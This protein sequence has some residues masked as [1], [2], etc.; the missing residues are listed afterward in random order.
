MEEFQQ[1]DDESDGI[2]F[3]KHP[4]KKYM[5][6]GLLLLVFVLSVVSF[7]GFR[8]KSVNPP[9]KPNIEINYSIYSQRYLSLMQ[10][11]ENENAIAAQ[12]DFLKKDG[13]VF[14][15]NIR[16]N[17]SL[18]PGNASIIDSLISSGDYSTIHTDLSNF[19]SDMKMTHIPKA[20]YGPT[21]YGDTYNNQQV[22]KSDLKY[23]LS[24]SK[25]GSI[26]FYCKHID[27]H[28]TSGHLIGFGSNQ[29]G[30]NGF[31]VQV[32]WGEVGFKVGKY[33]GGTYNTDAA[34]KLGYNSSNASTD[35]L[36]P[37][38]FADH[39]WH[40][41]VLSVKPLH[42]DDR[43]YIPNINSTYGSFNAMASLYID[44]ILRINSTAFLLEDC[45]EFRI[46]DL[47]N[48]TYNSSGY[49][50]N[51]FI[52][53]GN[54]YIDIPMILKRPLSQDEIQIMFSIINETKEE[55]IPIIDSGKR[56]KIPG[57]RI[58]AFGS[59]VIPESKSKPYADIEIFP[60]TESWI[61]VAFSYNK[62]FLS[63]INEFCGDH[64][65]EVDINYKMNAIPEW[66]NSYFY[67]Y[68]TIDTIAYWIPKIKE[69][70]RNLTMF[71]KYLYV[72]SKDNGDE[73][74]HK[75]SNMGYWI[76]SE[77]IMR[78]PT[79]SS[80]V[81]KTEYRTSTADFSFFAYF[82]IE[83]GFNT[84][85]RYIFKI[86]NTVDQIFEFNN[87]TVSHA[88]KINQVGYSPYSSVRYSYIG[89]WMGTA[90]VLPLSKYVDYP[91][92]IMQGDTKLY[93][94]IVQWR[95]QDEQIFKYN[96]LTE[97]CPVNGEII[98]QLNLSLFN[99]TGSG[100]Q[101]YVPGIGRSHEF[102]ISNSAIFDSFYVHARGLYHQRT[103]IERIKPF[104]NW[105]IGAHHKG[106]F[107][108]KHIPNNGH[109]N[110]YIFDEN[111]N[112]TVEISQFDMIKATLTNEFWPEV[113]GGHADAGDYDNRPY[114]LRM[115]EEITALYR[116]NMEC[117]YDHQLNLPESG[118]GI[119]DILSEAAWGLQI[120][121]LIQKR[122][123]TGAVS[124]WI[125][126]TSHPKHGNPGS[127]DQRYYVGLST[128]ECTI[129]YSAAAA[130]LALAI[131]DSPKHKES[132]VEKWVNSSKW[133]F[134]WAI[135]ES[136][137]CVYQ[138]KCEKNGKNLS[139]VYREP[140]IPQKDVIRAAMALYAI[141]KDSK[142]KVYIFNSENPISYKTGM[143]ELFN[144][145]RAGA[146]AL[147]A[148]PLFWLDNDPLFVPA[149]NTYRNSVV[150][151]SQTSID[152]QEEVM[153]YRN[154]SFYNL[155]HVYYSTVAWG[156]AMGGPMVKFYIAAYYL[157]KDKKYK[158]SAAL[159]YDFIHGCNHLGRTYVSG[160][161]IIYPIRFLSHPLWWKQECG[162]HDPIPGITVYTFDGNNHYE[163]IS[164]LYTMSYDERKDFSFRGY[165]IPI[166]PYL[167]NTSNYSY[168][169]VKSVLWKNIPFWR[170]TANLEGYTV[171]QSEFTVWETIS[172]NVLLAGFL[173]G[174]DCGTSVECPSLFPSDEMKNRNPKQY[175]ELKGRWSLP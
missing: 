121:Y 93:E 157:T 47:S 66:K 118:D 81:N 45:G 78:V 73:Y 89:R 122:F 63:Q 24:L 166:V 53:N 9:E 30:K 49:V 27:G 135:N 50:I 170:R 119:P 2:V 153:A 76:N 162:I 114:H 69:N 38:F 164:K 39:K 146:H 160:L 1:V 10:Y 11:L 172:P 31:F 15:E 28:S 107:V 29:W 65:R 56:C 104:T 143:N 148:S 32:G 141:T 95:K 5:S 108:A 152:L 52:H 14:I 117:L 150:K 4:R 94:G 64:L 7:M 137:R 151:V 99:K 85:K 23:N 168:S 46:F 156:N 71:S 34:L 97:G 3:N 169:D 134:D 54:W 155:D 131:N 43:A 17:N 80:N 145:F 42:N 83:G 22:L 106:I 68:A 149:I 133:A 70:F 128:R 18:Y 159:V 16:G 174:H 79:H 165:N 111:T 86:N 74:T 163:A 103:G 140:N 96:N 41:I 44:G 91:F 142:Y 110:K 98:L 136:N 84:G 62:F 144:S 59:E 8:K 100:Y 147:H 57:S 161:G 58:G 19:H 175:S 36:K 129:E 35:H 90:G 101:I 126:A 75:I 167:D 51:E 61:C 87:R 72:K 88:I 26:S 115:I 20:F 124:T 154:P 171:S 25:G 138:F 67:N 123:N 127:D 13:I 55:Q 40:H 12:F 33:N 112:E 116:I 158:D 48:N 6:L 60:L 37:R 21:V 77:G 113:N 120:H 105:E 109:Y 132:D 102:S 173:L 139:L 92:F 82:S 130:L 125:E